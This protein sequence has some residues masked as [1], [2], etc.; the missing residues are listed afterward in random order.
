MVRVRERQ[1]QTRE[2]NKESRH[3]GT[4]VWSAH[5][6]TEQKRFRGGEEAVSLPVGTG[7]FASAHQRPLTVVLPLV[8]RPGRQ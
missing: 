3:R 2:Q 7:C 5:L 4:R 6:A 1:R 8:G